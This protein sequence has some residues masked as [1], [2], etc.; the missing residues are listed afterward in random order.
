[1]T[2]SSITLNDI[3]SEII[4]Y[5]YSLDLSLGYKLRGLS[6]RFYKILYEIY[7][8]NYKKDII[9]LAEF[10]KGIFDAHDSTIQAIRLMIGDAYH[11]MKF[12]T[13]GYITVVKYGTQIHTLLLKYFV[14]RKH[15]HNIYILKGK[16]VFEVIDNNNDDINK[17][18]EYSVDC[19]YID[20]DYLR[21]YR[22]KTLKPE[23][24]I[25]FVDLLS[26]DDN[27][28]FHHNSDEIFNLKIE[29]CGPKK[30]AMIDIKNN[31]II[32]CAQRIKY[33]VGNLF[34]NRQTVEFDSTFNVAFTNNIEIK[35]YLHCL[36]GV[37]IEDK[38]IL[39][40]TNV[41]DK[42][43]NYKKQFPKRTKMI[44]FDINSSN[45]SDKTENA[46][47]NFI[48]VELMNRITKLNNISMHDKYDIPQIKEKYKAE[49][50][51]IMKKVISLCEAH[52]DCVDKAN[53]EKILHDAEIGDI[54]EHYN[55]DTNIHILLGVNNTS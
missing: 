26:L 52:N 41:I 5:I 16:M 20:Y 23:N 15:M 4:K 12:S 40:I 53:E 10:N 37:K 8:I 50:K 7:P 44:K 22:T 32:K 17:I 36:G 31:D 33:I 30:F 19:K 2:S 3:P 48:I 38:Y 54:E 24:S 46:M 27:I 35:E 11:R 55:I 13:C 21:L 42:Y 49:G 39:S 34:E 43:E 29:Y 25:N 1:M 45:D 18:T 14:S 9:I 51:E 28:I 6:K 47:E